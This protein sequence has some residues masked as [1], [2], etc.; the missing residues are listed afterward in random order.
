MDDRDV[1]LGLTEVGDDG[2]KAGAVTVEQIREMVELFYG[3]MRED[4]LVGPIFLA[5]VNDWEAHYEKMTR[6]W[7][8]AVLRTGS[9]SGRP[10][11]VHRF[12]GE[13][14][15]DEFRLSEAHFVR[16]VEVYTQT[17]EDVFGIEGAKPFLNVARA[18]ASSIAMRIGVG[19]VV[20][21]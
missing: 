2:G 8:S 11:E 4:D 19:R 20:F 21:S 3:R 5:R 18:M 10:L 17:A 13:D 14:G 15:G 7:S 12:G 16:W 1:S 9:Y 6:F